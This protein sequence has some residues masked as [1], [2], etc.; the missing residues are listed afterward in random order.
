MKV[1]SAAPRNFTAIPAVSEIE[2]DPADPSRRPL[3]LL[4]S[5][6]DVPREVSNGPVIGYTLYWGQATLAESE[7]GEIKIS[8]RTTYLFDNLNAGEK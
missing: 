3:A 8:N 4:L 6:G 5:W 1:P 2:P 7:Y